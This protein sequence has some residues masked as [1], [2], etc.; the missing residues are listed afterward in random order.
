M[1]EPIEPNL[2]TAVVADRTQLQIP[3]LTEWVAPTLEFLR[4]RMLLVGVCDEVQAQRLVMGLHEGLTNAVVHG[5]LEIPST[6]KEEGDAFARVLAERLR[7]PTYS[8][9]TVGIGVDYDGRR[10]QWT[11]TDEG[12]GFDYEKVLQ[13]L[14]EDP[15]NS[16]LASG[17]GILMMRAFFDD[18]RWEA[19]GR[20]L[21]MTW[22][23]PQAAENRRHP[24]WPCHRK[25]QVAPIRADGSVDWSAASEAVTRNLSASGTMLL[26][27]TLAR[28][29]RVMVTF[30]LDGEVV[31]LPA[32][33]RHC[34][35]LA[36]G[37]IELGCC[38]QTEGGNQVPQATGRVQEAIDELLGWVQSQQQKVDERR[39]HPRVAYAERV[40]VLASETQPAVVG[41]AQDLSRGGL[42]FITTENI[43]SEVRTLV[44]PQAGTAGLR[45]RAEILRC[46]RITDMFY[47]VAAR[48]VDTE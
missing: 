38:F 29:D 48:F 43:P 24:R 22:S 28:A 13:R 27:R 47:D 21:I 4:Q 16:L 14:D 45:V 15:E 31:Y 2:R 30:D 5:N 11:I 26:Q 3:S 41:Y 40:E 34:T 20:R 6:L 8:L 39:A 36:D 37:V 1:S 10:C 7:D 17:R 44:L 12:A 23:A 35:P 25:V 18:V 9:R 32:Q 33:V 19:G 42:K 46:T